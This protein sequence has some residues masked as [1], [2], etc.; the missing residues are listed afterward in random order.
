MRNNTVQIERNRG[1]KIISIT[2][3]I[4]SNNVVS[5][6]QEYKVKPPINDWAKIIT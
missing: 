4:K 5:T 2:D 1:E 6:K 3:W